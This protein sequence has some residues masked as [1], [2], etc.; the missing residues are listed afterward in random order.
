M[1]KRGR[2]GA[3]I[4]PS[5]KS[6]TSELEERTNRISRLFLRKRPLLKL[7][8]YED[9]WDKLGAARLLIVDS[10][11]IGMERGRAEGLKEGMAEGL[12]KGRAEGLAEGL[13]KGRT[14]ERTKMARKMLAMNME[15][16]MISE[17]TGLSE[18]EITQLS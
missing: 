18:K 2:Y 13:E 17:L 12:E 5:V 16:A 8:A 10:N 7:D 4:R 15:P 11:K 1:A 14:D 3:R 9:F 6:P